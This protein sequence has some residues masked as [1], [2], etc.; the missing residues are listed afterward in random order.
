MSRTKP[1]P[2]RL[3]S[4]RAT[5]LPAEIGRR[6]VTPGVPR[7]RLRP[8]HLVNGRPRA[9]CCPHHP[10]TSAAAGSSVAAYA[11]RSTPWR[12]F[13]LS[14]P[15]GLRRARSSRSSAWLANRQ[16]SS[17]SA[18][19]SHSCPARVRAR[20]PVLVP[21]AAG[22]VK[23]PPGGPP[24][25][26]GAA[27]G[28]VASAARPVKRIDDPHV[29]YMPVLTDVGGLLR[30]AR[31]R[32]GLTQVELGQRAG[33]TQS[34]VSA[35]ESGHRQP[36]LPV[37]LELL[38]ASGHALDAS[39]VATGPAQS[40]RCPARSVA[41][42]AGTGAGSEPSPRPMGSV[43]YRCSAASRAARRLRTPTSTYWW[44]CPRR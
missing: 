16:P 37:L 10:G 22:S 27:R 39:L 6:T 28:Y 15:V 34:V 7:E 33:V 31:R 14:G 29:D 26:R 43:A 38:R 17:W 40:A 1:A 3:P 42:C 18:R 21:L 5:W 4:T 8:L 30:E 12:R 19:T 13:R 36:S 2:H 35:Y 23:P 11:F 9:G 25:Y 20:R 41:G 24:R 32:A 44:T